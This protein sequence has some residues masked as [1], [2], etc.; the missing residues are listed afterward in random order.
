MWKN[1]AALWSNN[2]K[3]GF[4]PEYAAGNCPVSHEEQNRAS[5][6]SS[7]ATS[8]FYRRCLP[9]ERQLC[10]RFVFRFF[11][12]KE[13]LSNENSI[14]SDTNSNLRFAVCLLFGKTCSIPV[15]AVG[16]KWKPYQGF[17]TIY[18]ALKKN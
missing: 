18:L 10:L 16:L 9:E 8:F 4:S 17:D 14:S 3:A 15:H 1:H 5:P 6:L 11:N 7:Q 13:E 12:E 2:L